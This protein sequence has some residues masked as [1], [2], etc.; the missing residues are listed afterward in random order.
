MTQNDFMA[1]YQD[2]RILAIKQLIEEAL[3]KNKFTLAKKLMKLK[4]L[5]ESKTSH[6]RAIGEAYGK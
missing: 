2:L 1:A 4:Q 5:E 3:S 6:I